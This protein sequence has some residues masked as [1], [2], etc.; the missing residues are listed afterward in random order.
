[1]RSHNVL[2]AFAVPAIIAAQ[3]PADS[4]DEIVQLEHRRADAIRDGQDAVR[5]YSPGYR[6]INGLGQYETRERAI[7][8]DA[9][10]P[11]SRDI[12]VELQGGTAIVTGTETPAGSGDRDR[13]LR[14]WTRDRV[15]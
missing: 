6:G 12:S 10:Q 7:A 5:F 8:R 14:I 3:A 11:R 4:P 1:M 2:L 15:P 9:S 13:V